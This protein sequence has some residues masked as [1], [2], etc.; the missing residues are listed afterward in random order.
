MDDG[1][2]LLRLYDAHLHAY[3]TYQRV[4]NGDDLVTG[5]HISP[6]K[7]AAARAEWVDRYTEL[8]KAQGYTKGRIAEL[9]NERLE[10][11]S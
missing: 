7:V 3:H 4:A 1:A 10:V 2:E 9:L 11:A 8:R 6:E 5:Q